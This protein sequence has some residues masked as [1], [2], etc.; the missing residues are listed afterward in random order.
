MA[1]SLDTSKDIVPSLQPKTP[2]DI[3]PI[4]VMSKMYRIWGKI[5]GGQVALHLASQVPKTIGG[6]CAQ[7]SSE[8]IALYTSDRIE[9]ALSEKSPLSGVVLDIIK[10]YNSIP[11]QP[12]Q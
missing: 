1:R 6:P 10:C 9:E 11:R 7:V 4:T 8:M 3:R 12:L 5:R 2:L